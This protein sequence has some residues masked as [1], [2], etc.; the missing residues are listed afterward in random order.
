MR[1]EQT[2]HE[3]LNGRVRQLIAALDVFIE[4]DD[5]IG[6]TH[7]THGPNWQQI[8]ADE[9]LDELLSTYPSQERERLISTHAPL[10]SNLERDG[11][12]T[13]GR[14]ALLMSDGASSNTSTRDIG[15]YVSVGGLV[16][17]S[18]G[19]PG[20]F[21]GVEYLGVLEGDTDEVM[22]GRARPDVPSEVLLGWAS[23][24]AKLIDTDKFQIPDRVIACHKVLSVGGDAGELPFCFSGNEFISLNKFRILA[25]E[26]DR[27]YIPLIKSY[28]DNLKFVGLDRL[29]TA[30]F[31]PGTVRETVVVNVGESLDIFEDDQ[32]KE[33]TAS[34]Q[35]EIAQADLKGGSMG[36][37]IRILFKE[38]TKIWA[39]DW[40]IQVETAQIIRGDFYKSPRK[41][42]VLTL[43]RNV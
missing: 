27:I 28:G 42:W 3:V 1:R 39:N 2:I 4:V 6:G 41:R 40:R 43:L 21:V 24:Q 18:R 37:G 12:K 13:F 38:L 11:G 34:I 19:I 5:R 10:L 14:A 33:I 31:E 20:G 15:D 25:R 22:R 29:V 9:F 7:F 26:L 23:K 36:Q 30:Y 17:P 35:T 16:F 8:P 32:A